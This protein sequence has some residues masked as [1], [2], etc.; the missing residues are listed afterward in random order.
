MWHSTVQEDNINNYCEVYLDLMGNVKSTL[1]WAEEPPSELF[2]VHKTPFGTAELTKG[3]CQ[4][5]LSRTSSRV[6]AWGQQK[7]EQL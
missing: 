1:R 2:T 6:R 4:P 7:L 3:L 5:F